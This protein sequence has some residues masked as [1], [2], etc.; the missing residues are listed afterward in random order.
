MR[1]LFSK[2]SPTCIYIFFCL[3]CF[4]YE[5]K[6][7]LLIMYSNQDDMIIILKFIVWSAHWH[8]NTKRLNNEVTH[9]RAQQGLTVMLL[10]PVTSVWWSAIESTRFHIPRVLRLS[11]VLRL[12]RY[13]SSTPS[14]W[15]PSVIIRSTRW[16]STTS[17]SPGRGSSTTTTTTVWART[18]YV[19]SER[20]FTSGGSTRKNKQMRELMMYW[21][22][23]VLPMSTNSHCLRA[24]FDEWLTSIFTKIHWVS[25]QWKKKS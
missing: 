3:F 17:S 14:V 7:L 8:L 21:K 19:L 18:V 23:D 4:V 9:H 24:S 10:L 16:P 20:S 1:S 11:G 12:T 25:V 6:K 5:V 13:S 15:W 2:H 22:W